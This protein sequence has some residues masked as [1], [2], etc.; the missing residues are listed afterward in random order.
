[1][2]VACPCVRALDVFDELQPRHPVI[3]RFY[4]YSF[5]ALFIYAVLNIFIAII[6]D[7]FFSS[8]TFQLYGTKQERR[9]KRSR[10]WACACMRMQVLIL[11]KAYSHATDGEA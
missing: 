11:T 1:M 5:I 3:S 7:A 6:E 2:C 9:R 8:K 4:V 10:A